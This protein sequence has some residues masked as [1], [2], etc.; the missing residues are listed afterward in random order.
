MFSNDT[1][2]VTGIP[3]YTCPRFVDSGKH[4]VLGACTSPRR[5]RNWLDTSTLPVSSNTLDSISPLMRCG[6]FPPLH[7]IFTENVSCGPT[8]P[9]GGSIV[10]TAFLSSILNPEFDPALSA[11]EKSSERALLTREF[12]PS[13]RAERLPPGRELTDSP[14]LCVEALEAS[15]SSF[16]PLPALISTW[17]WGFI[18]YM[19]GT[20]DSFVNEITLEPSAPT[21]TSPMSISATAQRN[22]GPTAL[23]AMTT[24][25]TVV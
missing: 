23:T 20:S 22:V 11:T 25:S 10:T 21:P 18:M 3:T 17:S 7:V 24:L 1:V 6:I 4:L 16:F 19:A 5:F 14:S 12:E 15:S 9:L 13:P 2:N 8:T